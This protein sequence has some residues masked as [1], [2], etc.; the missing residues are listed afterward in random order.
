MVASQPAPGPETEQGPVKTDG[1]AHVPVSDPVLQTEIGAAQV[2][3]TSDMAP[4]EELAPVIAQPP[5][6]LSA[7]TVDEHARPTATWLSPT[8]EW[9]VALPHVATSR[10]PDPPPANEP[11]H[12]PPVSQPVVRSIVTRADTSAHTAEVATVA[13]LQLVWRLWRAIVVAAKITMLSLGVWYLI[14]LGL[15]ALYRTVDPPGSALM[16]LRWL[17]GQS[18]DQTF[19]PLHVISPA[20]RRAVVVSED[21]QFCRHRGFDFGEIRSA[22]NRGESFGRGA[23]TITQQLAKNLFLWPERSYIRKALEVP[24]TITIE[25]L[26]PKSRIFEVY[27]NVAEWGPGIFGAEAAARAYF[28]KPA[29][30]LSEREAALLAVALPNPLARNASDPDALQVRLATRL[31]G[32]MR[33]QMTFPCIVPDALREAL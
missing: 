31:Q 14:M 22:I 13:V 16:T 7:A 26:W 19:V 30:R 27:L 1:A 32:R 25:Q 24:L 21:G 11:T 28:G 20:L 3:P 18:I 23:S 9:P 2:L 10:R 4:P 8:P 15:I 6:G 12:A 33:S 5:A 17:G 29:N